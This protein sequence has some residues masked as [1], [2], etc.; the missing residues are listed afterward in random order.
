MIDDW[1]ELLVSLLD[2][3]ARYLVVGAHALAVH[4]VPRATQDLDV[5][6]DPDPENARRV[7]NALA[8]F[9]APLAA[10]G[11]TPDDLSVL[12]TVVQVGVPPNRVDLLTGI[13]GVPSF[14]EAWRT[15][16]MHKIHDRDVPFVD[17]KTLVANKRATGRLKDRADL[18]ALGEASP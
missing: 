7:W 2:S 6:V 5:W 8:V 16:V 13:T 10:L 17:R 4:G 15:R 12:D 3:N 14:A 11:I 1:G 18:E 9:G